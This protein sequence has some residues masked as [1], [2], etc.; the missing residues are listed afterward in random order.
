MNEYVPSK[1]ILDKYADV[2]INFALNGGE[3]V[4]PGE[5]VLITVPESARPFYDSLYEVA[6]KAGAHPMM[7]LIAQG[8]ELFFYENATTEQL[9]FFPLKYYQGLIDQVDHT[10]SVSAPDDLKRLSSVDKKKIFEHHKA[11]QPAHEIHDKKEH[12]GKLFWTLCMYGTSAMAQEAGL[13]LKE[14]WAEIIHACYLDED[15][16]VA[17]WKD[18]KKKADEYKRKLDEMDIEYL[19]VVSQRTNLRIGL[20]KNR[21]W[22]GAR[23]H[24]IPSFELF[25]SP[26]WRETRG[27]IQFT[28][29]LYRY[30]NLIENAYVEFGDDGCVKKATATQG[31]E[32]LLEM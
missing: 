31:E 8:N 26:D 25:I 11:L 17:H 32:V 13:S 20:G 5:V 24:N 30:G 1:E 2:M 22:L 23:C 18:F 3:G 21:R 29:P 6:I 10:I 4:K 12:E 27:N 28:E 19:D 14:Y 7:R 9:S 15:D 16:P